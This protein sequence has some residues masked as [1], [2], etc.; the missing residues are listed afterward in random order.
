MMALMKG[1]MIGL[2]FGVPIGAVGVLTIKRTITYGAKAGFIS[3]IGCSAADLCYSSI[4]V[5]GVTLVSDFMLKYQNIITIIGG[6]LVIVMGICFIGK[7]QMTI[8]EKSTGIKFLS[9]F[10]SSFMIAI[11]NPTTIVTFMTAFAVFNISQIRSASEGMEIIFGI[12]TGTCIWWIL[13]SVVIGNM[14]KKFT[15]KKLIVIN[16]ILGIIVLLFG[17]AILIK[18]FYSF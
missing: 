6:I 7:K 11:T 1:I 15:D 5:F 14:R 8:Y 10:T 12:L 13:I 3:G 9:F 16:Y 2:I 4:S 17:A 18:A